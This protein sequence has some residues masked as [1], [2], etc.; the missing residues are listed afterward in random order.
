[1]LNIL[2]MIKKI[3]RKKEKKRSAVPWGVDRNG[4]ELSISCLDDSEGRKQI[5]K[6]N[7]NTQNSVYFLYTNSEQSELTF[8]D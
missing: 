2:T 1:M 8:F 7:V 4:N 3:L 6:Y 5:A